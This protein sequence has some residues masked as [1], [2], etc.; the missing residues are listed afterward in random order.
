VDNSLGAGKARLSTYSDI[1]NKANYPSVEDLTKKMNAIAQ[2][3]YK[4]GTITKKQY[5]GYIK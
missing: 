2:R 3:L 5:E 4:N 1:K